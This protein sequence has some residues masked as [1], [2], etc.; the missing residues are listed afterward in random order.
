MS[1]FALKAVIHF[2]VGLHQ[3]D[4]DDE[5]RLLRYGEFGSQDAKSAKLKRAKMIHARNKKH[6][7]WLKEKVARKRT[8]RNG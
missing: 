1:L 3:K 5:M 8:Q 6:M 4:A 7:Q 2:R